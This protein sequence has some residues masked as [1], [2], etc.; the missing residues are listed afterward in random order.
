MVFFAGM[1][2][3]VSYACAN[4]FNNINSN[5]PYILATT[6]AIALITLFIQGSLTLS[7]MKFLNI[8]IGLDYNTKHYSASPLCSPDRIVIKSLN[9]FEKKYVYPLGVHVLFKTFTL[10]HF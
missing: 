5:Q 1:R 6:T 10:K 7:T 8:E 2:G 4:I 3:I 9:D